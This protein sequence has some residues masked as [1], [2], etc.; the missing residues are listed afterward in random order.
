MLEL[1]LNIFFFVSVFQTD[2]IKVVMAE[3]VEA[4]VA[5]DIHSIIKVAVAEVPVP[6]IITIAGTTI[7]G[8]LVA[9]EM[10]RGNPIVAVAVVDATM[11]AATVEVATTIILVEEVEAVAVI[12]I[13]LV[14]VAAGVDMVAVVIVGVAVIL[15][16]TGHKTQTCRGVE[17]AVIRHNIKIIEDLIE[18]RIS[19]K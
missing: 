18:N 11:D 17:V 4:A 7:L 2:T 19:R 5:E 16:I 1:L 10:E 14:G 9:L 13:I 8:E 12:I 6:N 3:A 15:I